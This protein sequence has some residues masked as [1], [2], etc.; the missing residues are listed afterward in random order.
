MWPIISPASMEAYL[1]PLTDENFLHP[2][3]HRLA[4]ALLLGTLLMGASSTPTRWRALQEPPGGSRV[5]DSA[6]RDRYR[7]AP[8]EEIDKDAPWTDGDRKSTRLNSSHVSISYAVFCLKKK[9]T[10]RTATQP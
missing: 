1:S 6:G 4:I 7:P 2:S 3:G 5:A 9:K 8:R 10:V